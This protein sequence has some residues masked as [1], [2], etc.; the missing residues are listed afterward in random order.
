M[1]AK[2]LKEI[3]AENLSRRGPHRAGRSTYYD[4]ILDVA[5]H[6]GL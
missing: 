1:D 3:Q 5:S 6:N 2:E 4:A